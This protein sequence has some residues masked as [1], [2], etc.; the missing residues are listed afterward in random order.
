MVKTTAEIPQLLVFL[1]KDLN[2][3]GVYHPSLESPSKA[4]VE[5]T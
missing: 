3:K 2:K 4:I 1:E 5:I